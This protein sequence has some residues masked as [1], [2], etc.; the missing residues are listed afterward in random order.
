MSLSPIDWLTNFRQPGPRTGVAALS[1]GGGVEARRAAARDGAPRGFPGVPSDRR[2]PTSRRNLIL[3][4]LLKYSQAVA[5]FDKFVVFSH[6]FW[7]KLTYTL[8]S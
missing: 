2:V 3:N 1:P 5:N 4:S 7:I 6:Q 8:I